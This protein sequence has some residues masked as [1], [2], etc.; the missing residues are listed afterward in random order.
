MDNFIVYIYFIMENF[1]THKSRENTMKNHHVPNHLVLPVINSWTIC[2]ICNPHQYLHPSLH[3]LIYFKTNSRHQGS[4]QVFP[5]K[6]LP[7]CLPV[8]EM[9]GTW[10]RSLGGTPGGGHGNPSSILTW[11]IP[12]QRN[13]AGYSPWGHKESDVTEHVCTHQTP[14][15][16][17]R[18]Y[19]QLYL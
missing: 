11:K 10:V 8:Q 12:W 9:Q 6:G 1:N 14:K 4:S 13:L 19:L 18:T 16:F 5:S 15:H 7:I 3:T 2:F 17:I